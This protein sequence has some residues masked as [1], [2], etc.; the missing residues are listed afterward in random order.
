MLRSGHRENKHHQLLTENYGYIKLVE[1]LAKITLLM[2]LSKT[3]E[4]FKNKFEEV[5]HGK[6]QLPY[7]EDLDRLQ[8][9]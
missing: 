4:H 5:F 7:K 2:Q 9:L 3:K 8:P 6:I 1:H